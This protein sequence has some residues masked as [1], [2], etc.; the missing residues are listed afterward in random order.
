M[1]SDQSRP[2]GPR[3]RAAVEK[4]VYL[5]PS[6]RIIKAVRGLR[7]VLTSYGFAK[8][9]TLVRESSESDL[10]DQFDGLFAELLENVSQLGP[11]MK[12]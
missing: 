2:P 7:A 9:T 1:R 6:P 12:K 8:I 10:Y 5:I 3:P 11:N 4:D